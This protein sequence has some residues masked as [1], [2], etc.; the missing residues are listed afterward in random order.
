MSSATLV[1][2]GKICM[3]SNNSSY[4][5]IDSGASNHMTDNKHVFS[6]LNVTNSLV[7]LADGSSSTAI[8]IGNDHPS[9]NPSLNSSLYIPQFPMNLLSM[10]KLIKSLNCSK[11]FFPFYCVFRI[12]R[13][14]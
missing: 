4:W 14:K 13:Q 1:H 6:S 2:S 8:G 11:T 5:I 7:T 9:S 12:L 10:S 3:L